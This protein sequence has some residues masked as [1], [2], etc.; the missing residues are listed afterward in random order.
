MLPST[1]SRRETQSTPVT[2]YTVIHLRVSLAANT[3]ASMLTKIYPG[4]TT[5]SRLITGDKSGGLSLYPFQCVD[6]LERVRI[7]NCRCVLYHWSH[8]CGVDLGFHVLRGHTLESVP[9]SK[10]LGVHV[11]KDLSWNDHIQ[12]T[13]AKT[14]RSVG[15][16]RRNL[17]GCPQD[18]KAQVYTTL[19]R[20]VLEYAST[21]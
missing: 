21:V 7:P 14:S 11:S 13:S 6:L 19:V 12:R 15:F 5:Y 4:M 8:Q 1:F 17:K 2:S 9:G 10:Y 16:L 20:P 18:V 3:L